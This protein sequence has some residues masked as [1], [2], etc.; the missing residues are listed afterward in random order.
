MRP[1]DFDCVFAQFFF[2]FFKLLEAVFENEGLLHKM[3]FLSFFE[4]LTPQ[5]C[6]PIW[7]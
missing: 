7:W 6:V 4:N 3:R 2:F 1:A 5:A